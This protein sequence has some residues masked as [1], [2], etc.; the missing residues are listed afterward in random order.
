MLARAAKSRVRRSLVSRRRRGRRPGL[1]T[2][3]RMALATAAFGLLHS[4]LA[5]DAAKEAAA[6][7]IGRARSRAFYRVAYNAQAI[8]TFT[9]L[10]GY[11][12]KLPSR[13]IY[14]V[15]GWSAVPLRAGQLMGLAW[16]YRAAREPGILRLSGWTN[17]RAYLQRVPLPEGPA[18]QGPERLPDGR[19]SAGGP[20]L[21]S[22]HPLNFAPL[23]VFWL[24]P[25]LTTRRLGFNVA[26]TLYLI[27]GSMHE[28]RRLLALYGPDYQAYRALGVPFFLPRG[29]R[30]AA[31]KAGVVGKGAAAQSPHIP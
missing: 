26:A 6:L 5:T 23:P 13:P 12:L 24:T 20:F 18:A 28:E 2:A 29:L 17:L 31:P 7:W 19:L 11:A 9:F 15:R 30:F 22:R 8:A 3:S 21:L 16:A 1:E 27:V 25:R 10:L 4:L 14:H